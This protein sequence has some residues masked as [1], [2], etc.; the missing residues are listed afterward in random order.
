MN[1]AACSCDWVIEHVCVKEW[2][3]KYVYVCIWLRLCMWVNQWAYSCE[4]M[5]ES[6]LLVNV[7]GCVY[8]W[9]CID[10]LCV[11]QF[12]GDNVI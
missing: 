12:M 5:F 7:L 2:L 1:M 11:S 9:E 3:C 8:M 4:S 10:N 6:V